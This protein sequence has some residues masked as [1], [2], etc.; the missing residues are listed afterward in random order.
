MA[1]DH[2]ESERLRDEFTDLREQVVPVLKPYVTK[3][4]LFGSRARG[5][6]R[7]DSD[8]DIVVAL[9]SPDKRPRLGLRWFDLERILSERVGRPVEL[10]TEDALSSHVSPYIEHD[11]KVLYEE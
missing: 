1:S 9:K 8:I 6:D 5:E 7:P 3:I 11:R 2:T 4:T 10:V